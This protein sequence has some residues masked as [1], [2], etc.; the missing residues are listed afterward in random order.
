AEFASSGIL[1]GAAVT[2]GR[3]VYPA[4]FGCPSDGELVAVVSGNSNPKFVP[5]DKLGE[6]RDAVIRVAG[7]TKTALGQSRVQLTF[8]EVS[9]FVYFEPEDTGG[10]QRW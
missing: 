5:A 10:E 9:G 7:A 1:V 2:P 4:S 8:A 3:V 6:F